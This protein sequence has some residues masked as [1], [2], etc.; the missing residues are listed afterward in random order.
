MSLNVRFRPE[1]R[2]FLQI[3]AIDEISRRF[4]ISA[5]LLVF[6]LLIHRN[7]YMAPPVGLYLPRKYQSRESDDLSGDASPTR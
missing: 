4:D 7:A 1:I 3:V 6:V 2:Q 5:I